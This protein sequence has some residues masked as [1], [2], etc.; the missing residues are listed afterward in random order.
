MAMRSASTEVVR[1]RRTRRSASPNAVPRRRR[2]LPDYVPTGCR[3]LF[4]GLNPGLRSAALGHRFAGHTNKLWRLMTEA[5]FLPA[6]SSYLDDRALP[7]PGL[8]I[9]NLVARP[10]AGIADLRP[11][12]YARGRRA[13]LG[14][15]Q[16]WRPQQVALLGV[17]VFRELFGER[18]P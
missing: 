11:S 10:T 4:V 14:R 7:R 12:D 3:I 17:T 13:L 18:G 16:R 2:G 15:I 5:G 1:A 9:T 8:G 6:G